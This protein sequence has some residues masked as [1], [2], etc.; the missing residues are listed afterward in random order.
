MYVDHA[1]A[2]AVFTTL[3]QAF[4]EGSFP[5]SDAVRPQDIVG[6]ELLNYTEKQQANFWFFVCMYMRGPVDSNYATEQL[7]EIFKKMNGCGIFDPFTEEAQDPEEIDKAMTEAK[8]TRLLSDVKKFWSFNARKLAA[9]YGG[10]ARNIFVGVS[11]FDELTKRCRYVRRT[12]HGFMGF[13]K[14]MV[15]MITYF[16]RERKLIDLS[17]FPPPV[18]PPVDFHLM[19]IMVNNRIVVH[20]EWDNPNSFRYETSSPYGYEAVERYLVETGADPVALG[21][22]LW[23]LSGNL[24]EKSLINQIEREFGTLD[25]EEI[26]RASRARKKILMRHA[27]LFVPEAL[28]LLINRNSA[29]IKKTCGLCPASETCV[30]GMPST[31]Y[32]VYGHLRVVNRV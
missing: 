30:S 6:E 7:L 19:R 14:K 25:E 10:D 5:Y 3:L 23:L 18:P 26:A 24:C 22:A 21:D 28:P 1:R 31:S 11:S 15:S 8:F 4:Q 13:Q 2:D 12:S 17:D 20:D 27:G 9:E 16:L 32:Y 29:K